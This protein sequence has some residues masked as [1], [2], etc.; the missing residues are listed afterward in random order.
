MQG[1]VFRNGRC[2]TSVDYAPN[3]SMNP[4]EKPNDH[5]SGKMRT[6]IAIGNK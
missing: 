1:H 2:Y 4:C 6:R 3:F 5:I